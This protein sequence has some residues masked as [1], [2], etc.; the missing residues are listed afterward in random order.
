ME[1]INKL[2]IQKSHNSNNCVVSNNKPINLNVSNDLAVEN[3]ISFF[4][5]NYNSYSQFNQNQYDR[6]SSW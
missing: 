6:Q 3:K 2:V 4:Q 5:N 1:N